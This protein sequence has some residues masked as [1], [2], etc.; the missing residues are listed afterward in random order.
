MNM[1]KITKRVVG[2]VLLILLVSCVFFAFFLKTAYVVP[3]LMYHS[4]DHNDQKTK[5]SVSPESFERQVK[6][7]ADNHYNV[8]LLPEVVGYVTGKKRIPPKT[9]A[10]TFDD[11]FLNNYQFAYPVL[12]KYKIP[13]TIFVITGKIGTPGFVNEEQVKEMADSG[14]MAIGSHTVSHKWLPSFDDPAL[15]RELVDSKA[16]LEAITGQPVDIFCY[17]IG[18]HD[19]RVQ[20]AAKDAGYVAAVATNPGKA[21]SWHDPYAIKRIKISRTSDNLFVFW[22]ETSGYY[23]SIKEFRDTD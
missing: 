8:V 2:C 7:L 10:I 16:F 3:V 5:L 18:A 19:K 14:V 20:Q 11:G 22:M 23:T 21:A 12:K 13:A 6:F 1:K 17:P 4:I 15:R 9:V